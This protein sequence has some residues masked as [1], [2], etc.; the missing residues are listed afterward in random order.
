M[1]SSVCWGSVMHLRWTEEHLRPALRA[2]PALA[3]QG[4]LFSLPVLVRYRGEKRGVQYRRDAVVS[5]RDGGV[6]WGDG[7]AAD[8]K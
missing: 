8:K 5:V 4:L 3:G 7:S 1:S 2:S 6:G